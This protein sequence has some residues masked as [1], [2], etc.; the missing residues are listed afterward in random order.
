MSRFMIKGAMNGVFSFLSIA[1]QIFAWSV[2]HLET[3]KT[4]RIYQHLRFCLVVLEARIEGP[5]MCICS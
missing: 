4:L 5:A 1:V 2:G 3:T